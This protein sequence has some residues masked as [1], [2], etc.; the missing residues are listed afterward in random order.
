MLALLIDECD[1]VT[2]PA[3]TAF[4][5]G[6]DAAADAYYAEVVAWAVDNEITNSVTDDTFGPNNGC[7]RAQIVTFLYR[8]FA[9]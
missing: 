2:G 3:A 4:V 7:T 1:A 9:K 8:Y 6:D 5:A